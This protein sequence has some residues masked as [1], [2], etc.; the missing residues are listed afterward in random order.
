ML[1]TDSRPSFFSSNRLWT[2][3]IVGLLG[4]IFGL[5]TY[6]FGYAEG[7]AYLSNDPEACVNCH[8]MREQYDGWLRSSHREVAVCNDCHTP[9]NFVGKWTVKGINGFNH[10]RAFT[11]QNFHEPIQITGMNRD[12]AVESCLYCHE[13]YVSQIVHSP[14]GED[15]DC[16]ACH[17]SV[18]HDEFP[19]LEANSEP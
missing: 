11:L 16:L 8:V 17:G 2:F 6:T 3:S 9:H 13:A 15:A 10:S 1:L 4:I 19:G 7:T 14:S 18:G 5:G 12:V